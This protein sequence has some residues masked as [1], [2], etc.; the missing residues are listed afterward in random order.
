MVHGDT[1]QGITGPAK[2][3]K[4]KSKDQYQTKDQSPMAPFPKC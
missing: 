2:D 3:Q 1:N 4:L